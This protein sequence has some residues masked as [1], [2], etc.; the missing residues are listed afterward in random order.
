[1][2]IPDISSIE[3]FWSTIYAYIEHLTLFVPAYL[4]VSKDRGGGRGWGG[5]VDGHICP[6]YVFRVWFGL[7]CQIFL[8]IDC[9][10]MDDHIQKKKN[11]K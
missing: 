5:G 2:Y 3:Y 9:L 4:S 8:K 11:D 10:G 6:P 7:G 1:M